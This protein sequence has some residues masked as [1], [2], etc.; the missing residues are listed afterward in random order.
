MSSPIVPRKLVQFQIK[1]I[2][3]GF[4]FDWNKYQNETKAMRKMTADTGAS[5][6]TCDPHN[7]DHEPPFPPRCIHCLAL[8]NTQH[9]AVFFSLASFSHSS[10]RCVCTS[11][12]WLIIHH[13]HRETGW[14]ISLAELI[15]CSG[16]R[17]DEIYASCQ[18]SGYV[19]NGVHQFLLTFLF[20]GSILLWFSGKLR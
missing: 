11:P 14:D 16:V 17:A 3:L 18:R 20:H 7:T 1:L 15:A 10:A 9:A 13:S 2:P 4:P 6:T 19:W 12:R 5:D 8:P